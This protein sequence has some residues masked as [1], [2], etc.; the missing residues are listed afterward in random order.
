MRLVK[1][2]KMRGNL[3]N[4][5]MGSE[6]FFQTVVPIPPISGL[7][8]GQPTRSPDLQLPDSKLTRI[9]SGAF[10]QNILRR[11][12]VGAA[13]IKETHPLSSKR[14]EQR[15]FDEGDLDLPGFCRNARA[16]YTVLAAYE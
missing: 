15:P 16:S 12:T 2:A 13:G 8:R 10:E 14:L 6:L 3:K 5:G 11:P 9:A 4:E 7:R 1:I